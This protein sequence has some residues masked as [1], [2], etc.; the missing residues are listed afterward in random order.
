[1]MGGAKIDSAQKKFGSTSCY[2]DGT[3]DY[4]ALDDSPDWHFGTGNF[5]I[6]FFQKFSDKAGTQILFEQ[7]ADGSTY[8]RFSFTDSGGG[9]LNYIINGSTIISKAWNPGASAPFSWFH[10]ALVRNGNAWTLYVDGTSIGSATSTTAVLDIFAQVTIGSEYVP[11]NP[12]S[13]FYKGWIDGLRISKGIARWTGNFTAPTSAYGSIS[14]W[15]TATAYVVGDLVS[16][17]G[18]DY[19]CLVGHTS[20]TFATDLAAGYWTSTPAVEVVTPYP[21]ADVENL[22]FAQKDDVMYITHPSYAPRK[23][24]RETATKFTLEEVYFKEPPVMD[25]NIENIV[26]TPSAATGSGITLT[27]IGKA[28]FASTHVGSIWKINAAFVKITAVT[29]GYTSIGDVQVEP[30]GTAGNIG[31]T[32][33]Y[34]AWAE[35]EF[36]GYRGYPTSVVFHEGRLVYGM[37]N[38]VFGSVINA[39]DTFESGTDSSDAFSY[40]LGAVKSIRWLSSSDS[41]IVGHM[42]GTAS[43][44]GSEGATITPT[45]ILVSYDTDY[46]VA[47]ILPKNMSSYLYYIQASKYQVRELSYNF[48]IDKL[49]TDDMNMLADHILRDGGGAVTMARQMSPNDRLWVVRSDGQIAVLTRNVAQQVMGWCRIVM[50]ITAH[51]GDVVEDI[52]I[53]PEDGADDTIYVLVKRYI[54]GGW[55]RYV[56]YLSPEIFDDDWDAVRVDCALTLDSPVT[57]TGATAANPV[58]ITATSHGFSNGD[59]VKIDNVVGMTELNG[60]TYKVAD[61]TDH[62]FELTTTADVDV[63]G[64][65]YTAYQSGGEVRK[66]VTAIS[67]LSHLE[68]ESVTCQCDSDTIETHTVSSGAITLD[69]RAAVVHA[70]LSYEGTIKFMEVNDAGIKKSRRYSLTTLTLS[71]SLGGYI[72]QNTSNLAPIGI[73]A[74]DGKYFTGDIEVNPETYWRKDAAITVKQTTAYPMFVLA[75]VFKSTV[76]D[77]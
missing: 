30:D 61:K 63:D 56:E 12:V 1:M 74:N 47:A 18:T 39:Y 26:I 25:T 58:V 50:G 71:K 38:K 77:V 54:N 49:L 29:N 51:G 57:I 52:C 37:K 33:A 2:F 20:G 22:Q 31:G 41:I 70:G 5:T 23:L 7:C 59:Y 53:I 62:T 14:A 21:K 76:E 60:N 72:G 10:I 24:K 19:Y 6:E 11:G 42:N 66:K 48:S 68:G 34:K 75:A 35:P 32:L 27:V 4:I 17:G 73:T 67:G 15:L 46:G 64:T 3:S 13:S 28:L 40:T 36:S 44:S 65:A 16:N 8:Q 55:K 9:A 43:L 69:A 45:N